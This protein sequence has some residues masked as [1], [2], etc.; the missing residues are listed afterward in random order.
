MISIIEIIN[1]SDLCSMSWSHSFS[2]SDFY[3][4]FITHERMHV[5][6]KEMPISFKIYIEK[7]NF[8]SGQLNDQYVMFE[9]MI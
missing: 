5:V 3:L 1:V 6:D 2:G 9:A 7:A 4:T 8:T